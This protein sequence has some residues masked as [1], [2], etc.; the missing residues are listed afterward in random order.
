LYKRSG[1]LRYNFRKGLRLFISQ[2]T[3]NVDFAS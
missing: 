1:S 3:F 2:A